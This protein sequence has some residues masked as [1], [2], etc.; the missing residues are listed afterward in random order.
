MQTQLDFFEAEEGD[1]AVLIVNE[2]T[3]SGGDPEGKRERWIKTYASREEMGWDIERL[4]LVVWDVAQR[5]RCNPLPQP[6]MVANSFISD[7]KRT[8]C[9]FLHLPMTPQQ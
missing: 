9:T 6:A 2:C 8:L 3:A 5:I 7:P 4:G 1:F